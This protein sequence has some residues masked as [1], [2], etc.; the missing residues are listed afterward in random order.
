MPN[1]I[2]WGITDGMRLARTVGKE[3]GDPSKSTAEEFVAAAERAKLKYTN[4]WVIY[5]SL[6][7]KYQELGYYTEALKATQKCVELKPN[8]IRSVYALATSYNLITR[9]VWSDK[10]EETAHLLKLILGSEDQIDRRLSKGTLDRTGLTVETAA[11][12][13]IRW[14]EK[15]LTLNPDSQSRAQIQMD[16]QGLYRRFPHLKS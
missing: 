7:D 6:A 5:Y 15:A 9:A 11:V 14:F 10:E 2:R 12:Q 8:D 4:E 16:L 1:I 3:L 13:A